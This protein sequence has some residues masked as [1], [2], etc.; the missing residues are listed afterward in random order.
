MGLDDTVSRYGP[1][2]KGQPVRLYGEK[3]EMARQKWSLYNYN[4]IVSEMI[5]LDRTLPDVRDSQ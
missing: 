1:G 5:S 4:V 2:E 3:E